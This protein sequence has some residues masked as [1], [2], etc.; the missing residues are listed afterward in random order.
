MAKIPG[1]EKWLRGLPCAICGRPAE[2]GGTVV[3]HTGDGINNRRS[4]DEFAMPLCS[5]PNTFNSPSHHDE[6]HQN[7]AYDREVLRPMAR[8]YYKQ[9]LLEVE[10]V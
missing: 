3:H 7:P 4:M 2:I 6:A 9:Y 5:T 1:Y 8:E 10:N